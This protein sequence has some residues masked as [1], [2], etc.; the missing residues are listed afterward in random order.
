MPSGYYA[1]DA[2]HLQARIGRVCGKLRAPLIHA[3]F[4]EWA[5]QINASPNNP[6]LNDE[7]MPACGVGA[8]LASGSVTN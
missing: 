2:L 6:R 1:S 4:P 8:G 7:Y 3:A 5:K